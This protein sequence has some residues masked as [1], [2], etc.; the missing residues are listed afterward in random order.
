MHEGGL[1][2]LLKLFGGQAGGGGV[3]VVVV[4]AVVV[5]VV[6]AVVVVVVVV[7]IIG[8]QTRSIDKVGRM[9]SFASVGHVDTGRQSRVD[10]L[11]YDT[12]LIHT[13]G[14]RYE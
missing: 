11:L 1:L 12:P 8:P 6:V 3:V 14:I 4:V 9:I 10:P 5:V 2:G 7:F 13:V